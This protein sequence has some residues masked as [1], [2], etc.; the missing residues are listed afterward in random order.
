MDFRS[1]AIKLL[2]VVAHQGT[3]RGILF[4]VVSF[5]IDDRDSVAGMS[6]DLPVE[7]GDRF[8]KYR[9]TGAAF[10]FAGVLCHASDAI[11]IIDSEGHYLEQNAAHRTLMGY[12]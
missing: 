1:M 4:Q 10:V 7:F 8:V 9:R 2:V 6:E 11:A 5:G 3:M 12:D